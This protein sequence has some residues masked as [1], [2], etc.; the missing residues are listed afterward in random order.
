MPSTSTVLFHGDASD[1]SIPA[2]VWWV[3]GGTVVTAAVITAVVVVKKRQQRKALLAGPPSHPI[4]VDDAGAKFLSLIPP[5]KRARAERALAVILPAYKSGA[6]FNVDYEDAKG[7]LNRLVDAAYEAHIQAPFLWGKGYTEISELDSKIGSVSG[8]HQVIS[9]A[10][11]VDKLKPPGAYGDAQRAFAEAALPMALIVAD[12]KSKVVKGR[13]PDPE[14]AARRAI[15]EAK[16]NVQTCSVCFRGIAVLSNGRIADH[17]YTLPHRWHKTASCPGAMFRPLEVSS[18]GLVYMV[19]QLTT[20]KRMLRERLDELPRATSLLETY[21]PSWKRQ[22]RTITPDDT[23][24]HRVLRDHT[25][26]VASDLRQTET[27][28]VDYQRRLDAWH[29][30]PQ[31]A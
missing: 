24:W 9:V 17:G 5:E 30:G 26:Q 16:K 21:G 23:S 18:D 20:Q 13:K 4:D 31:A 6:I 14:A 3:A 11:K 10:K 19:K 22:Q 28:L 29:P 7:T 15:V 25:G 2:W 1:H 8:L 27:A 12:L